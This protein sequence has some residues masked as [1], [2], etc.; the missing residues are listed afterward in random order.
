MKKL[1]IAFLFLMF[2]SSVFAMNGPITIITEP[3]NYVVFEIF[4]SD[5]G[6]YLN[7]LRGTADGEGRISK[8]FFSLNEP[9]VKYKIRIWKGTSKVNDA[10][11]EGSTANPL[12]F[13][14]V[15]NGECI[16]N[17]D[18]IAMEEL[19]KKVAEKPIVEEV[20]EVPENIT[21]EESVVE[22]T[23]DVPADVVEEE[24]LPITGK[25][26]FTN[27]DGSLKGYIWFIGIIFA[28]VFVF[29]L[30]KM[31][32]KGSSV[33]DVATPA[34]NRELKK[35]QEQIRKKELEIKII[36]EGKKQ[37]E[38]VRKAKAKLAE[39]EK[40]LRTLRGDDK[41]EEEV[42]KAKAKL[43]EEEKEL[44]ALKSVENHE[45][46]KAKLDKKEE[47]LKFLKEQAEDK[48]EDESESLKED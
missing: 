15:S 8:T 27:N 18:A 33:I 44:K 45:E 3:S 32:Y 22:N 30:V 14:C 7:E 24:I 21:E 41:Q 17:I 47:E 13:E 35:I 2:F 28:L 36:K 34:S 1:L 26:I 6:T 23:T 20:T 46:A 43:A 40:E 9:D 4:S 37:I 16:M 25:A 31:F 5:G 11:L 19:A 48:K 42:R 10:S 12:L 38:E 29:L 39:E